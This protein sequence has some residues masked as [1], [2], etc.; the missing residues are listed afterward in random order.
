[1]IIKTP[2]KALLIGLALIQACGMVSSP[3][4]KPNFDVT[5]TWGGTSITNCGVLLY[6]KYRCNAMQRIT[7]TLFQDGS[8]LSGVYSCSYGTMVCFNMNDK[9]RIVSSTLNGSLARMRVMMPDGSS[10]IFNGTFRP[11]SAVGGFACYQ[12]GGL[13]EQGGWQATRLY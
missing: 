7:F 4:Q 13:L 1:M 6:D 11:E 10:C 2:A 8:D 9:G 3:A 5:G 12:G